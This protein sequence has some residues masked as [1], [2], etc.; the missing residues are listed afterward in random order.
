MFKWDHPSSRSSNLKHTQSLVTGLAKRVKRR[1]SRPG[2]R[3]YEN[4]NDPFGP[5]P[6]R[7]AFAVSRLWLE[8]REY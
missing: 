6:R 2:D 5:D 8:V 3:N 4:G 7:S 1:V